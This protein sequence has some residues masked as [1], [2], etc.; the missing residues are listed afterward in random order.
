[1]S[2]CKH[3]HLARSCVHC[4]LE[5]A[6]NKIEELEK[7][8]KAHELRIDDLKGRVANLEYTIEELEGWH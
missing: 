5:E 3:G 8:V 4:E 1:M 6:Y 7:L 2:E